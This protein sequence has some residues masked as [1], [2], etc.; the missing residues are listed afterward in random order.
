M[1]KITIKIVLALLCL[2]FPAQS[3]TTKAR[4]GLSIGDQMPEVSYTYTQNNARKTAKFSDHKGKLVIL[5]FWATWCSPCVAMIP[6]M[7]ALQKQ[8]SKDLQFLS[9]TYQTATEVN[10]LFDKLAKHQQIK[11][12]ILL[13]TADESFHQLFPHRELPH[14]VWIDG[15]GKVVAI[16]GHTEVNETNIKKLIGQPRLTLKTKDD[17]AS[18]DYNAQQPLFVNG[19]G[20]N[21]ETVLARTTFAAYSPGIGHG[22]QL[23]NEDKTQPW[24]FTARNLTIKQLYQFAYRDMDNFTNN[25][26]IVRAKDPVELTPDKNDMRAWV[27]S[28]SYC[29]ELI[30]PKQNELKA[31]DIVKDDLKT[32]LPRYQASVEK[33]DTKCLALIRTSQTDKLKTTG[34]TGLVQF[35]T[36]GC[37]L[38]NT[39]LSHLVDRLSS[40]YMQ[41]SALPI[42]NATNYEGRI[43]LS[44]EANLGDLTSVNKALEKYDL[45]FVERTI[46]INMLVI[47]SK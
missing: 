30:L 4:K 46:P 11:P 19:N 10:V 14:Y 28:H 12:T 35:D 24:K 45:Q 39:Y 8:F 38:E 29:Y 33:I 2:N 5:D 31:Y 1:K 7:E 47:S 26:V 9:I 3:Q 21:G 36:Y 41:K 15:N 42:V 18:V 16:T 34:K 27:R 43:D 40:F 32:Y 20:G 37:R 13:V 22:W 44:L 6:K 17:E 23:S 25:R